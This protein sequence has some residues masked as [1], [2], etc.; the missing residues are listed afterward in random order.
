MNKMIR[1][2]IA[3]VFTLYFLSDWVLSLAN[4]FFQKQDKLD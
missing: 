4:S 3:S 1:L 2:K